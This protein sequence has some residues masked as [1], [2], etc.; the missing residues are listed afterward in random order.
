MAHFKTSSLFYPLQV[1]KTT[2]LAGLETSHTTPATLRPT[3]RQRL[4]SWPLQCWTWRKLHPRSTRSTKR[5]SAGHCPFTL[6]P[7]ITR[8]SSSSAPKRIEKFQF[9]F[10]HFNG[11]INVLKSSMIHSVQ[12]RVFS[13]LTRI[14][15]DISRVCS[16]SCV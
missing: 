12:T 9:V 14:G 6:K 7:S 2:N 5:R 3:W 15:F 16:A 11:P 13:N 1:P 4:K 8:C 10:W